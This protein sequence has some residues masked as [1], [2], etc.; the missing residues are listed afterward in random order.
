MQNLKT[1]I[2]NAVVKSL[3]DSGS[4]EQSASPSSIY[5]PYV[6]KYAIIRSYTSG[7]H[8]GKIKQIEHE[9]VALTEARRIH[10]WD[11]ANSCTDIAIGG[12]LNKKDSRVAAALDEHLIQGVNEVIPCSDKAIECLKSFPIWSKF[13][14][15]N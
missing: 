5:A 7:V 13:D 10:Y 12:I 3:L 14:G 15:D 2:I 9:V 11:G 6:G 1:E 8:F 4:A